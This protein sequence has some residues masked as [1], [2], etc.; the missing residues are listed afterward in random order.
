MNA[1]KVLALSLIIDPWLHE[2]S[3]N[4]LVSKVNL[5]I[6][7]EFLMVE[8]ILVVLEVDAWLSPDTLHNGDIFK[9]LFIKVFGEVVEE[10]RAEFRKEVFC[11]VLISLPFLQLPSLSTISSFPWCLFISSFSLAFL[12][13][14]RWAE[15]FISI[16]LGLNCCRQPS[17]IHFECSFRGS[18]WVFWGIVWMNI[19]V[20]PLH[21]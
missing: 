17:R 14:L 10:G 6:G 8:E 1:L 3:H 12:L 15:W 19:F 11:G 7:P 2:I 4:H 5:Q 13:W 21:Q 18:W 20:L 16:I 9:I